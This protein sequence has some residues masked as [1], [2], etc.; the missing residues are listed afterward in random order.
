[1][2]YLFFIVVKNIETEVYTI[3]MSTSHLNVS[4]GIDFIIKAAIN[5]A[6]MLGMAIPNAAFLL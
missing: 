5:T 6:S 2:F 3:I 4:K 1:M